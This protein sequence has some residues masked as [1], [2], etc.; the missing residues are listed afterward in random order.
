MVAVIHPGQLG[1]ALL[2]GHAVSFGQFLD[3]LFE[4]FL[5]VFLR[6]AADVCVA[7]IHGDVFEVVEAAEDGEFANLG[8]AGEEAE[9]DE[10]VFGFHHTVEALKLTTENIREI[11]IP[12]VLHNWLIVFINEN[13]CP[14]TSLGVC[15]FY[16]LTKTNPRYSVFV[17]N[18]VLLFP[19]TQVIVENLLKNFRRIIT[20]PAQI[21]TQHRILDPVFL[22]VSNGQAV[23]KLFFA[24]EVSLHRGDQQTL[25]ETAGTAEEEITSLLGHLENQ[26]GLV[27][28]D[29]TVFANFLEVL[30]ANRIKHFARRF[31]T[32]DK[33][34]VF[35]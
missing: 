20:L 22:Q 13:D 25:S 19:A 4:V 17:L 12:Q 26:V 24:A 10:A 35:F 11:F 18:S 2:F 7:G 30:Y 5:Q 3:A 23:K 32:K 14:L 34:K 28:I 16:N 6:N 8:D 1:I 9:L 33:V 15:S 31:L 29:E 21:H 27:H